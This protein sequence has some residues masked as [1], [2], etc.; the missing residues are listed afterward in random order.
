MSWTVP[1]ALSH[2]R[3]EVP[4]LSTSECDLVKARAFNAVIQVEWGGMSVS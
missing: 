2:S 1:P 3:A 4:T